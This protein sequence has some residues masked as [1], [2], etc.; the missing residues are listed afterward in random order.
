MPRNTWWNETAKVETRPEVKMNEQ[1]VFSSGFVQCF[2]YF[3][4]ENCENNATSS[5]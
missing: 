5:S 4:E 2:C 1:S 3:K